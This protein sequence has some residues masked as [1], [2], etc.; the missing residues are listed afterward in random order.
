MATEADTFTRRDRRRINRA[1]RRARAAQAHLDR[2][3]APVA[4][5]APPSGTPRRGLAH[6][7]RAV[8]VRRHVDRVLASP[9][10]QTVMVAAC[11]AVAVGLVIGGVIAGIILAT[12]QD[13]L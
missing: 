2:Q 3:A 9:A 8:L 1:L 4:S 5:A 11:V 13:E 10:A 6:R 12:H 7:A